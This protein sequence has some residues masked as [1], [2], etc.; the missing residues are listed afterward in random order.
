MRFRDRFQVDYF[1]QGFEHFTLLSVDLAI[2]WPARF[3][4]IEACVLGFGF[5]M[6]VNYARGR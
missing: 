6:V 4:T 5:S 2:A 3:A 1:S